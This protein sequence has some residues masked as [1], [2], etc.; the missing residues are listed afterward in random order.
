M[1]L[2]YLGTPLTW[3]EAKKYADHVRF[4]GI[5][6]FLH[7][8]DRL[9]DRH[10]DEL[11][12]GDEVLLSLRALVTM[13][14]SFLQRSSTWSSRLTTRTRMRSCLYGRQKFWKSSAQLWTI[15]VPIAPS[16][17]FHA[18][19]VI[20]HTYL[21]IQSFRTYLSSRIWTIHAG[22][23]P[24]I[25]IYRF[26]PRSVVSRKQHALPVNSPHRLKT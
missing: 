5:T 12:W 14:L 22:I 23:D 9:K 4:H 19:P 11:L 10:G 7:I 17:E 26:P 15:Y 18:E 21:F 16:R 24:R 8:W 6:Q 20:T 25:A 1:G 2:L 3:D 13:I